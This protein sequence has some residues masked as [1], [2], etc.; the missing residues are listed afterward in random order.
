MIEHQTLRKLVLQALKKSPSTNLIEITNEVQRL[1]G[2]QNVFP[3]KEECEKDRTDYRYYQNKQLNP[4]DELNVNQIVWD[5]IVDRV[6]TLGL[7]K[8]N[9]KWPFLRLTKFGDLVVKEEQPTH[10]DPEGYSAIL[11]SFTPQ[12]DPVIKQYVLEGL[13]CFRQRLIFAAAVMFGAAAEKAVLLLLESIGKAQ[14]DPNKKQQIDK[15][16]ERGRLPQIFSEIRSSLEVLIKLDRIPYPTH[17]GSSEHLLSLYEMIRVQRNDA[18]HP[19]ISDV[20]KTKVYLTSL[21]LPAALKC[22]YKLIEWFSQNKI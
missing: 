20:S 21:S 10:Y 8:L 16:L 17:E 7:D 15:L 5:L 9:D 13:N 4:I 2:E 22:T 18:V 12:I 11:E 3:T 19:I 6:L 14:N 1:A